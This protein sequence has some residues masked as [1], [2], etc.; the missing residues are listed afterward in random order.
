MVDEHVTLYRQLGVVPLWMAKAL[1]CLDLSDFLVMNRWARDRVPLLLVLVLLG[2]AVVWGGWAYR[3][4][5]DALT[6]WGFVVALAGAV[7][8]A[9]PVLVSLGCRQPASEVGVLA[10]QLAR[11]W[12][13][14]GGRQRSSG[15]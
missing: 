4:P 15:D 9:I 14:S 12:T 8:G 11:R 10:A 1:G 13:G 5:G 7:V 6:R 3:Q 2:G